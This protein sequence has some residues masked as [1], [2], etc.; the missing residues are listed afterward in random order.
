MG[1]RRLAIMGAGCALMVA[2]ACE[3]AVAAEGSVPVATVATPAVITAT[4]ALAAD[5][6]V[7][8]QSP[9]VIISVTGFGR[10]TRALSK[11]S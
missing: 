6:G 1:N 4:P 8:S 5:Q 11:R 7:A 2:L 9:R 10:R 3:G